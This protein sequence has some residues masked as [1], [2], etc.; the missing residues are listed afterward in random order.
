MNL[1]LPDPW[2][3]VR[4]RFQL[5]PLLKFRLGVR[6]LWNRSATFPLQSSS[7]RIMINWKVGLLL[8]DSH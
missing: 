6:L 3:N 1:A 7:R 8:L 4:S 2:E 5:H